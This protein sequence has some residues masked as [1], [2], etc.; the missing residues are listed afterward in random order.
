MVALNLLVAR[1]YS[2]IVNSVNRGVLAMKSHSRLKSQTSCLKDNNVGQSE[3]KSFLE[4][5][6]LRC[7]VIN[8]KVKNTIIREF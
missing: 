3:I 8:T 2:P 1:S 4:K 5:V 6:E 7:Q